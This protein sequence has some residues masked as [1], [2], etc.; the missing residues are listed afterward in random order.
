MVLQQRK[1][2]RRDLFGAGETEGAMQEEMDTK[3]PQTVPTI[4]CSPAEYCILMQM[5]K[6]GRKENI[7]LVFEWLT[8]SC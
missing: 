3:N 8:T 7:N 1:D 2:W 6:P 4:N 5:Y